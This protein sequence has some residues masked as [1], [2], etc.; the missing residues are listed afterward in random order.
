MSRSNVLNPICDR[1]LKGIVDYGMAALLKLSD[2]LRRGVWA[3]KQ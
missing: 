3:Y 1:M 2:A